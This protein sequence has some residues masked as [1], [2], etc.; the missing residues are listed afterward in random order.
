MMLVGG[1]HAGHR[2]CSQPSGRR[3]DE[4]QASEKMDAGRQWA[5]RRQEKQPASAKMDA[6]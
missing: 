5:G 2:M 4:Q 1:A 6:G 3:Q